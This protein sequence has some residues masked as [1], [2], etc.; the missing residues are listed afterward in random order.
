[1]ADLNFPATP[2][3]GQEYVG[4][5]ITYIWT[6]YG[7]AIKTSGVAGVALSC[8]FHGLPAVGASVF[9]PITMSLFVSMGLIGSVGYAN[10]PATAD[11][12]FT[13][14]RISLGAPYD[15]GTLTAVAGSSTPF[16]FAG[17]GGLL[18]PGEVLQIIAPATADA[19]LAD[20]GITLLATIA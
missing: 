5:G 18:L 2:S 1:M 8:M 15:F 17:P 9:I 4:E 20:V 12:V 3:T 13:V 7:W 11:A 10:I 19:T 16:T 6:G 14:K